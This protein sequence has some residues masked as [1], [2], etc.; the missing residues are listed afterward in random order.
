MKK[1]LLSIITFTLSF[2]CC[3]TMAIFG[4]LFLA[5]PHGGVLPTWTAGLVLLLGWTFAL[6]VPIYL[7]LKVYKAMGYR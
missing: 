5:G 2:M 3:G 4:V 6:G 1:W 7:A